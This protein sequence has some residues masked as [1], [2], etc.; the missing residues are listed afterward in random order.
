MRYISLL[1][2]LVVSFGLFRVT[3]LAQ[4]AGYLPQIADVEASIAI[5]RAELRKCED[6]LKQY[7][8]AAQQYADGISALAEP[9]P[10]VLQSF[11][12]RI[13]DL[14]VCIAELDEDLG[15][16]YELLE[17]LKQSLSTQVPHPETR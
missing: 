13:G 12:T 14:Q 11:A 17:R 8:T 1:V 16:L 6:R 7:Q 3:A 9:D 5:H 10:A 2:C 15:D 4:D